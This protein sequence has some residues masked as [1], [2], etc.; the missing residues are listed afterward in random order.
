MMIIHNLL[1]YFVSHSHII[2]VTS[3]LF[4][5]VVFSFFTF[6]YLRNKADFGCE[7]PPYIYATVHNKLPNI[8]KYSR[9]GCLLS[10]NVLVDGP[11]SHEDRYIELRSLVIGKYKEQEALYLADA[12]TSD[13]YVYVYGQC[14]EKTGQRK[15]IDKVVSTK[16][17]K[18]ADHTY[19]ICFDTEGNIYA[20]FQHTDAVLRFSKD[21]FNELPLP[22]SLQE[23]HKNW[24]YF[25]GK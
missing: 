23:D 16:S 24:Q 15:Y 1:F 11:L 5:G 9:N 3:L 10:S 7:G 20:S 8:L 22:I 25:P 13:S 18:G 2:I 14:D 21:D 6:L 17:N 12:T 19:G 4:A